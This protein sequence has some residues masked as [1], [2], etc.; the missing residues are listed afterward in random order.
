MTARHWAL[1]DER[2]LLAGFMLG[3]L[4]PLPLPAPDGSTPIEALE[5]ALRPA[6]LRPPCVIGFSGGRDSS[7][8]LAVAARVARRDDL[9]P[10]VPVSLRFPAAIG[11]LEDEYR[12]AVLDRV[13]VAQ[14]AVVTLSDELD[15]I[16]PFAAGLLDRH[17]VV[18]PPN[19]HL[20]SVLAEHARG[21]SLVIGIGGDEV[22]GGW[23]LGVATAWQTRLPQRPGRQD[24]KRVALAAAPRALRRARA[25]RERAAMTEWVRQPTRGQL[26]DAHARDLEAGPLRFD[27]Y[28]AWVLRARYLAA[29]H[30]TMQA[31]AE[32]GGAA[33]Y[34]PFI[35]PGFVAALAHAGGATGLGDRTQIMERL[36]GDLLPHRVVH[37]PTKATFEGAF[38]TA[39]S[40][41]FARTWDGS[42]QGENLDTEALRRAWLA[43]RPSFLTYGLLQSAWLASRAE[44]PNAGHSG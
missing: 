43:E 7:A 32:A 9:E 10:P 14:G 39:R 12:S 26:A 34:L 11:S 22:L 35:E 16:G 21:G 20:A 25:S 23:S 42:G 17:G 30:W 15:L 19:A 18:W 40:R 5:R 37:R 44:L 6:L 38:V 41:S 3:R 33:A 27:R 29:S 28:L 24:A 1:P 13:D 2:D 36:F 31:V 8:L 4:G